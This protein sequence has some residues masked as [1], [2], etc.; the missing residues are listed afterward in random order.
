MGQ[1]STSASRSA[2]PDCPRGGRG[3]LRRVLTVP[4]LA[5][6]LALAAPAVANADSSSSLTIV[7]T[8]D[9]SDSG[10]MPNLIQPE[11]LA[12]FPQ[13]TFRYTGSATGTAIT[14]A[15]NGTG[16]PSVL[17]VHAPSLENQFVANG[18]SYEQYGRA[19]FTNDFVLAGPSADPAGVKVNGANNI[20][21]AFAD[22][23]TAGNN[24]GGTPLVTFVSRGGTPGTTVEE[25]QIWALVGSLA[26]PPTGLD[27]CTVS[28]ADGGGETPVSAASGLNGQPCPGGLPPGSDLP[29]WYVTT[30]LTQGP[31]VV[32]ANACASEPSPANTCY[33]LTDRGTY[34]YLAS[35]SDPAGAIPNLSI[36]TRNSSASAPGGADLLINYFHAY[37]INP[38]KPNETVNL[39][40]AEDF[41]NFLTSP[42]FQS[43]LKTYL[44][45]TSDTGGPP[46]VA[47]AS[48]GITA[49]G[50]P[51]TDPA[52]TPITVTGTLTNSQPGFPALAGQT[53]SV[54]EIEAG[55]PVAL[56]SG[57]TNSSGAYS[58]TF[59][60]VSSGSYQV[61]T[62]QIA[63]IENASLNPV[64][65]D[66][67]SP[68]ATSVF[69]VNV[70]SAVTIASASSSPGRVTVSGTVAPGAADANAIV[71]LLARPVGSTGD[72]RNIGVESL[73]TG[74]ISYS[75]AGALA[76]GRW[77]LEVSYSDPGQLLGATSTPA[78]ATVS[79]AVPS[80]GFKKVKV[81]G[82]VV[83]VSGSLGPA[84]SAAGAYVELI[85]LRAG[86]GRFSYLGTRSLSSGQTTFTIKAKLKRRFRWVLQLE[87]VQ[88]GQKTG[89]SKLQSIAVH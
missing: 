40:A 35:G 49:S 34:D 17:I 43:Q 33:V 51:S 50:I 13:F 42:S 65:G 71:Q 66:L 70:Q 48:P 29:A 82:G 72:Y 63:Q 4:L 69:S 41:V 7:G 80:I 1:S 2:R 54:D 84:E 38:A 78:T 58:I 23:A 47:D 57:K 85:G 74:S 32:S 15:E 31:N 6:L 61:S 5:L 9:V 36:L 28:A 55:L 67:L 16:G 26:S 76:P 68:A 53:V 22:I 77:Q 19:I 37:I 79:S 39:V 11:F 10:L 52:G 27:L 59:T 18:F 60:P 56:A 45:D 88:P 83:T 64:F 62:G 87:Y 73:A 14:N 44:D 21:Q 75:I 8:S 86:S 20:V 3:P 25:H 24:G 46:F 12:A 81:K 30:G 89:F